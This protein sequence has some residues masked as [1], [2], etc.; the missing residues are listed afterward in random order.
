LSWTLKVS[1]N[2]PSKSGWAMRDPISIVSMKDMIV[3]TE[4]EMSE[5]VIYTMC[6][7]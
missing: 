5:K 7:Q 2:G 1:F 3:L 4:L 6:L